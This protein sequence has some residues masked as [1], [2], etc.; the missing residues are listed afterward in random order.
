MLKEVTSEILELAQDF[1]FVRNLS[2]TSILAIACLFGLS[3]LQNQTTKAS[4]QATITNISQ[5]TTRLV[6]ER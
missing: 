5:S 1:K 2:V 4:E 6:V 3:D